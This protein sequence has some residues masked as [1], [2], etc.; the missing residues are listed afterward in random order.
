MRY[1]GRSGSGREKKWRLSTSGR[2]VLNASETPV[3]QQAL[4]RTTIKVLEGSSKW[5]QTTSGM[6]WSARRDIIR[7]SSLEFR[8]TYSPPTDLVLSYNYTAIILC[9]SQAST[10]LPVMP[11]KKKPPNK[12]NAVHQAPRGPNSH[13]TLLE[14][15]IED[16]VRAGERLNGM[17]DDND[18]NVDVREGLERL[19]SDRNH[20]IAD[21]LN[22]W[23]HD[24]W[25]RQ[26]QSDLDLTAE[27]ED[28]LRLV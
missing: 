7:L 20:R 17:P 3:I 1:G 9:N 23:I 22:D 26:P 2:R 18:N 6:I 24:P 21:A 12:P 16:Q 5:R 8:L 4:P 25:V 27:D 28:A 13:L 14:D 11:P 15:H 19:I 10:S